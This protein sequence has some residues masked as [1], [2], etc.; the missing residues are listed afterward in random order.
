MKTK[1]RIPRVSPKTEAAVKKSGPLG[2]ASDESFYYRLEGLKLDPKA[3]ARWVRALLSG[4]YQQGCGRLCRETSEGKVRWCCLAV[5]GD[6]EISGT[7]VR[8]ETGIGEPRWNLFPDDGMNDHYGLTHDL[9]HH[10]PPEVTSILIGMNDRDG[11][12]FPQIAAW[13]HKYL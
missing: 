13:I 10:L 3:K 1:I 12:S 6:V 8:D 9:G 2:S 5:Y 7:W 11:I 4:K